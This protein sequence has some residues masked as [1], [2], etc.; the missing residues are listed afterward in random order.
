MP[1]NRK[2]FVEENPTKACLRSNIHG[3]KKKKWRPGTKAIRD[4]RKY[5]GVTKQDI[6]YDSDGRQFLKTTHITRQGTDLLIRKL[7]FQRIVRDIAMSIKSDVRFET[8]ALLAL[9]CAAESHLVGVFQDA[10]LCALHSKRET[11]YASDMR[12]AGKI[13]RDCVPPKGEQESEA[14]FYRSRGCYARGYG[15]TLHRYDGEPM[16]GSS[17]A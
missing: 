11:L 2:L 8:T 10:N 7:P 15:E 16:R 12:L 9:Q 5:Q 3:I 17:S 13:R 4:I 1:T 6:D 14:W